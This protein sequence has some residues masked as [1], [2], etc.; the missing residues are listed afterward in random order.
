MPVPNGDYDVTLHFAELFWNDAGRRVFDVTV[1][2]A[3][4]VSDLDIYDEVGK[5]A[6]LT[7]S[8]LGVTVSDGV[9]DLV[10]SADIDYAAVSA[11]EVVPAAPPQPYI[12]G[13]D[14]P[15]GATGPRNHWS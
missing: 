10:L 2:G 11:I 13:A 4:L 15:N 6:A 7:K 8:A 5:F 3:P 14:P 12:T 1:E 9:L